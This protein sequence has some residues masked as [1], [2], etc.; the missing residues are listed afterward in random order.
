MEK[1]ETK[2]YCYYAKTN[3]GYW[4]MG[5]TAGEALKAARFTKKDSA[6]IYHGQ[7]I[8]WDDNKGA[9]ADTWTNDGNYLIDIRAGVIQ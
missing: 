7:N 1:T 5:N 6:F 2:T 8:K 4:G 3:Q 9:T